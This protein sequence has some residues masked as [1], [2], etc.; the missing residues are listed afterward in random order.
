LFDFLPFQGRARQLYT[1]IGSE[2]SLCEESS[3]L[4]LGY[5]RDAPGTLDEAGSALADLL[6]KAVKLGPGDEV[7]DVGF[8]FGDQDF[9]WHD[10][11]RPAKITGVNV[12]PAQVRAAR[13]RAVRRGSNDSIL[14]VEGDATRLA[15]PDGHFDVVFALECAFHFTTREAFFHEA[16]RVLR[17]GGR[18]ALADLCAVPAALS[19]KEPNIELMRRRWQIPKENLYPSDI[20]QAKLAAAGFSNMNLQSIWHDVVP[21]YWNFVRTRLADAEVVRRMNPLVLRRLKPGLEA[22]MPASP[23]VLDYVLVYAEKSF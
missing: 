13:E 5:W 15:F 6:A 23:Q 20:Y 19:S 14:F 1:A 2:N 21:P 3:Y 16:Y 18:L 9:F 22:P 7:L 4:N 17:P 12:T 8:G 11:Y 10:T